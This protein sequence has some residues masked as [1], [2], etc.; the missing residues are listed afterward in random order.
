M[1]GHRDAAGLAE[2][3]AAGAAGLN[4]QGAAVGLLVDHCHWL[5]RPDFTTGF[6]NATTT[7]ASGPALAHVRWKAAARALACGRLP[8]SSGEAAL[9][10]LAASLAAD[11]PV[12]LGDAAG[13]LD[14]TNCTALA[15]A[16]LRA[17]GHHR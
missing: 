4:A 3:L 8:A 9:L 14:H 5:T 10:H 7:P 17:G 12:T 1:T 2:L 11:V 15:H 6:I 16:I 13:R